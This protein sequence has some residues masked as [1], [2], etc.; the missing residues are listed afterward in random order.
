MT[1]FLALFGDAAA[2]SHRRSVSISSCSTVRRR[3][4]R[5]PEFTQ[6]DPRS[7]AAT[8]E[9]LGP[10]ARPLRLVHE[11]PRPQAQAA[12]GRARAGRRGRPAARPRPR[13]RRRLRDPGRRRLRPRRAQRAGARRARGAAA[14]E[15][16]PAAHR[17]AADGLRGR[18]AAR[19]RLGDGDH[20][21]ARRGAGAGLLPWR[22]RPTTSPE[23][24]GSSLQVLFNA[25]EFPVDSSSPA[26]TVVALRR[27]IAR[28]LGGMLGIVVLLAAFGGALPDLLQKGRSTSCWRGRSGACGCSRSLLPGRGPHRAARDG[29]DLRRVRADDGDRS[30]HFLDGA[31]S[32][33]LTTTAA[34]AAIF[35]VALL[36]GLVTRSSTLSSLM[37]VVAYSLAGLVGGARENWAA[38]GIALSA[39]WKSALDTA[40]W[41]APKTSELSN[42]G[43]LRLGRAELSPTAFERFRQQVPEVADLATTFG[44]TALFA[45]VVLAIAALFP[46]R[47]CWDGSRKETRVRAW[48]VERSRP[49]AGGGSSSARSRS[50]CRRP[51]RSSSRSGVRRLPH[52]P[53]VCWASSRSGASAGP[54]PR[55]DRRRARRRRRPGRARSGARGR[56]LAPSDAAATAKRADAR[57]SPERRLHRLDGGRRLRG[58]AARAG[59]VRLPARRE[60]R[61]G[62]DG[63]APLR[64][65]RRV[66]GAARDRTVRSGA[67]ARGRAAVP[68][69]PPRLRRGR[70][71]RA[72]ARAGARR[73]GLRDDARPRAPPGAG[74]RARRALGRRRGAGAAG[75]SST[76]RSSR[77][78]G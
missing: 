24:E 8:R 48:R 20:A 34:F 58:A 25:K 7:A 54:S 28:I 39:T 6:P 10:L 36:V 53:H 74:A 65:D 44:T 1:A 16:R 4:L 50:R 55:S 9:L 37:A 62:R 46:G 51:T 35:P 77:S 11:P 71:P 70:P 60:L 40:W 73:G 17:A 64:R 13:R 43:L 26:E 23:L 21:L 32:C 63:A 41:I 27:P 61:A 15:L 52:R 67:R 29:G 30:G 42:L 47:D 59:R 2:R 12:C 45:A 72:A 68:A 22:R 56:R 19:P 69:R 14:R 49:I 66:P 31:S 57:T 33:A 76:P 5:E 38:T 3:L 78:G 18:R 75:R